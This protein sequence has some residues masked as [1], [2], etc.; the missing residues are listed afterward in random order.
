MLGPLISWN[1]T[2][3][4]LVRYTLQ[5]AIPTWGHKLFPLAF[6]FTC[7]SSSFLILSSSILLASSSA[8]LFFSSSLCHCSS[9]SEADFTSLDGFFSSRL[10]PLSSEVL[11]SFP[12]N[13]KT[14]YSKTFL[15]LVG[16]VK[17]QILYFH[18]LPFSPTIQTQYDMLIEIFYAFFQKFASLE[19]NSA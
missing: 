7:S 17:G 9:N 16:K 8:F 15:Y 2:I 11:S 3:H 13:H 6:R 14:L 4:V 19:D 1:I 18:C 12:L 5:S 10:S